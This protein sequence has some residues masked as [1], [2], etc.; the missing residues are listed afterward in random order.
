MG[1]QVSKEAGINIFRFCLTFSIAK[2]KNMNTEHLESLWKL[3]A[4][5]SVFSDSPI[6]FFLTI[7]VWHHGDRRDYDRNDLDS[8]KSSMCRFWNRFQKPS[9]LLSRIDVFGV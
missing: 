9:L 4:V 5:L 1:A 2:T 6:A 7:Y 3:S 8:K